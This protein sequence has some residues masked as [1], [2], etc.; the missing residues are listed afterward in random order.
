MFVTVVEAADTS[1]I[2]RLLSSYR[3]TILFIYLFIHS[4]M[5]N[6]VIKAVKEQKHNYTVSMQSSMTT[7]GR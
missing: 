6:A 1:T 5:N 7:A 4:F 3:V 2:V